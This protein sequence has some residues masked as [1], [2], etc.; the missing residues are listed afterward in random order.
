[1]NKTE[2]ERLLC[3]RT[4]STQRL[5][6]ALPVSGREVAKTALL[7]ANGAINSSS[8][9]CRRAK[10]SISKKLSPFSWL[11]KLRYPLIARIA[12][13]AR[14][15]HLALATVWKRSSIPSLADD[16]EIVFEGNTHEE[17]IRMKFKD[18]VQLEDPLVAPFAHDF[19]S[20]EHGVRRMGTFKI[21][22]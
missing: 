3:E 19:G 20:A 9:Y 8:P 13:L 12:T 4:Y 18:S 16:K 1:M 15:R 2:F 5:A 10:T 17:A 11:R 14:C 22:L 21:I 6:H 7:R